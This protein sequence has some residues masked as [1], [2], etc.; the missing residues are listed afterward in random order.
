MGFNFYLNDRP[1][2]RLGTCVYL[3]YFYL[4]YFYL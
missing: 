4:A 3:A 2:V 1:R